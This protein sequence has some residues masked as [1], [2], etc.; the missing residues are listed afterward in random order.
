[1]IHCAPS[2]TGKRAG[3]AGGFGVHRRNA[4]QFRIDLRNESAELQLFRELAGI[5]IADRARL[6]FARID[7][8]VVER[9]LPGL[10]NQ[11]PDGF[12]F[13][14][15]VA[16]KVGAAAAENVNFVHS[17][18]NLAKLSVLSSRAMR[19]LPQMLTSCLATKMGRR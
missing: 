7:L 3:S 12:A 10:G 14:F 17:I 16:L 19:G 18:I 2:K 5:E 9:F 1:M 11:V 8:R 6:D 13:L 4:A 15:Q